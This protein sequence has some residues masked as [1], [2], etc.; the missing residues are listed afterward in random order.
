MYLGLATTADDQEKDPGVVTGGT[1]YNEPLLTDST[2][3]RGI[4]AVVDRMLIWAGE[5]EIFVDG[6]REFGDTFCQGWKSGG[7]KEE[8]V[9]LEFARKEAHIGPILDVMLQYKAKSASQ[10]M[11][12]RW[13]QERLE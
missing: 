12:E 6:L 11:I 5:D 9:E 2:W 10:V 3:W 8:H 4:H 1:K 13:L 7:G